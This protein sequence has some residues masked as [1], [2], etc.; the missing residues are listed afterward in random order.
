M[1]D[2]KYTRHASGGSW[3]GRQ[4]PSDK[5][6]TEK[7]QRVID[8][9]R[10]Q[11][12]DTKEV[13]TDLLRSTEGVMNNESEN[14]QTLQTLKSEL[15]QAKVNNVKKRQQTEV[16]YYEGLASQAAEREEFWRQ[17]T[18]KLADDLSKITQGL[19]DTVQYW[20]DKR[21]DDKNK[22][23]EQDQKDRKLRHNTLH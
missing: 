1:A 16:D 12:K 2:L 20:R 18:P 5:K 21:V 11:Q 7:E 15:W 14:R 19:V 17:Y 3:K 4:T 6:V 9:L 13:R 22:Q 8:F 23:D 10:Q